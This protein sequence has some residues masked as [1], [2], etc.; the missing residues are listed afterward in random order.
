MKDCIDDVERLHG[1]VA[2][3]LFLL[4]RSSFSMSLL[5]HAYVDLEFLGLYYL[6]FSI[7]FDEVRGKSHQC[8]AGWLE[9]GADGTDAEAQET[10]RSAASS[11]AGF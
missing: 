9:G 3:F 11:G 10:V 7:K 5:Y 8:C 1:G 6:Y 2:S 4:M